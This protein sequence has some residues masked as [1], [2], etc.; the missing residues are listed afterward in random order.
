MTTAR[1]LWFGMLAAPTAWAIAGL[2]G[3]G[4]GS[5]ICTPWNVGTVRTVVGLFTLVMLVC[6][7]AGLMTG[8]RNWR[9]VGSTPR[10]AGDRVAF[11]SLGGVLISTSFVIGIVLFGLIVVFVDVCGRAR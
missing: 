1:R 9:E 4:F 10:A 11:M 3:W 8:I 5:Q 2:F 7:A 6:A